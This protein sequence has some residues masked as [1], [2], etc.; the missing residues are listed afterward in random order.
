MVPESPTF[1][2]KL[3]CFS[4]RIEKFIADSQ[5]GMVVTLTE[6]VN[7]ANQQMFEVMKS[8]FE[9]IIKENARLTEEVNSLS[10]SFK[11]LSAEV[12]DLKQEKLNNLM[13]IDGIDS[14]IINTKPPKDV[15]NDLLASNQIKCDMS[16]IERVSKR[17]INTVNGCKSLLVVSFRSYEDKMKVM[18]STRKDNIYFN[19][20]MTP[21]NRA[22]FLKSRKEAKKINQRVTVAHGKIYVKKFGQKHGILIKTEDDLNKLQI[23]QS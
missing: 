8:E 12:N 1:D 21:K 9:K 7:Q 19:H 4:D 11:I 18:M 15:L 2:E 17:E 14:S 22:L 3:K 6:L 23:N 5:A 10:T 20:M 13:E 16:H